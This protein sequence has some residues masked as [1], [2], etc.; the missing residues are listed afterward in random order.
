[1]EILESEG[2]AAAVGDHRMGCTSTTCARPNPDALEAAKRE[3]AEA[4]ILLEV[5]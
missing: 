1:M 2:S 5:D 3:L 4:G